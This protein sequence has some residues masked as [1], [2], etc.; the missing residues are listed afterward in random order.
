MSNNALSMLLQIP[1]SRISGLLYE[2]RLKYPPDEDYLK[3]EFLRVLG[4]SSF[5][6][7]ERKPDDFESIKV[8]FIVENKYLRYGIQGRLKEKGLLV[9]SSFNS[10]IVK[11]RCSSLIDIIGEL[12]GREIK[13]EFRARFKKINSLSREEKTKQM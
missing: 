8:T 7:D 5:E 4:K 11:M 3:S 12:Y 10:E 6:L 2:A 9:D 13:E 1:E